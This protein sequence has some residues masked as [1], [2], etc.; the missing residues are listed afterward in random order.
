MSSAVV[1]G[2]GLGGL[3]CGS[4]LSRQGYKVTVL[5]RGAQMGG[6][7]QSFVRGGIR[8]DTGFHSVAGL[9]PGEPLYRVFEPLDLMRLPW[10]KVLMA[11]PS[12]GVR[13]QDRDTA[14][15]PS[16]PSFT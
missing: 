14:T 12:F 4:I 9:A 16:M 7:L 1:I 5:E 10:R 13:M 8:F 6:C 2:S 11:V 3:L 15:S